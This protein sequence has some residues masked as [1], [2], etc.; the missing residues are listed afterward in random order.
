[1]KSD[2]LTVGRKTGLGIRVLVAALCAGAV[3]SF[4]EG[5]YLFWVDALK[6]GTHVSWGVLAYGLAVLTTVV[7]L[8]GA[9]HVVCMLLRRSWRPCASPV[10][11]FVSSVVAGSALLFTFHSVTSTV[12]RIALEGG[13]IIVLL[14][15]V[16]PWVNRPFLKRAMRRP[17]RTRIWLGA[18]IA[19]YLLA[20]L[21]PTFFEPAQST[22]PVPAAFE[23]SGT[24]G[25][26][27]VLIVMDTLRADALKLYNPEASANTDALNKLA[28]DAIVFT[29]A[30]GQAGWTKAAFASIFT[31]L[32]PSV[33]MAIGTKTN[34]VLPQ[35]VETVAEALRGK[36]YYTKGFPNNPNI[37]RA[38]GFDQGFVDYQDLVTTRRFFAPSNATKMAIYEIADRFGRLDVMDFYHPAEKVT[39]YALSWLDDIPFADDPF[40]LFVHYMDP[41][42]PYME[43]M[44]PDG[45]YCWRRL[46][47]PTPD[48]K[49]D[50]VAA[51]THEIE[52]MDRYI[53]ALLDGLKERGLYEN[54]M[55]V[56][57]NDHGEEFFDHQGW[58]HGRTLYEEMIRLAL[59]VKLP[60]NAMGGTQNNSIARHI[61]IAPTIL[62]V[63]GLDIPEAMQGTPL[64]DI[65]G[66]ALN[67]ST[68][69]SYA[70]HDLWGNVLR[71]VRTT[72]FKYIEVLERVPEYA[73]IFD[74]VELYDMKKDPCE[75]DNRIE[76]PALQD[77]RKN[78]HNW[79][80]TY[81]DIV[82]RDKMEPESP[83][84]LDQSVQNQMEALGYI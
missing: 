52:Y 21:V 8:N 7:A 65:T 70:E 82:T 15:S 47:L 17:G 31:G 2:P 13:A 54:S 38:C 75:Q 23:S 58:W 39:R 34:N 43:P 9:V 79:L 33:H 78:L 12:G 26:N 62:K 5:F 25:P 51:Y 63:A 69:T 77:S 22:P 14:V 41:H 50:I 71:S 4:L 37:F 61:D 6:G 18:G 42:D 48:M 20:F 67:A 83:A 60:D 44:A 73:H 27:I 35:R 76:L 80:A 36:G 56:V 11:T 53:G 16:L 74:P 19:L 84:Q 29:E 32:Y 10:V 45:G 66:A 57:V 68:A 30:S 1:M 55:I 3:L 49:T 64:C 59:M 28:S 81:R 40:F 24:R 72:R 46:G